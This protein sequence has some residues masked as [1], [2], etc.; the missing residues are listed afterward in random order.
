A[1]G[2]PAA[3]P[4]DPERGRE[5][6]EGDSGRH[7]V[8]AH[9]VADGAVVVELALVEPPFLRLDAAPFDREAVGGVPEL[10]GEPEVVV[11]PPVVV[12][13][14]AR[15]VAVADVAG[16]LLPGPPLVVRAEIGRASCRERV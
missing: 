5:V 8:A 15:D 14:D 6:M 9:R 16:L 13:R 3:G 1:R 11:E 2:L 10:G 12:A 4:R 7:A